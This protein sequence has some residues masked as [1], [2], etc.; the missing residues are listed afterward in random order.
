MS[1]HMIDDENYEEEYIYS[2]LDIFLDE[3]YMVHLCELNVENNQVLAPRE[4]YCPICGDLVSDNDLDICRC[5]NCE[6]EF[7]S[8]EG[9]CPFKNDYILFEVDTKEDCFYDEGVEEENYLSYYENCECCG[10]NYNCYANK[11]TYSIDESLFLTPQE[12]LNNDE[13]NE[14][15]SNS[16]INKND[17]TAQLITYKDSN[18]KISKTI[19]PAKE[20]YVK[21]E[22]RMVA[23]FME[24]PWNCSRESCKKI[25][26]SYG[27]EVVDEDSTKIDFQGLLFSIP[28]H[29][30][31]NFDKDGLATI[32]ILLIFNISFEKHFVHNK[33]KSTLTE[34]YG[35][36]SVEKDDFCFWCD[37]ERTGMASVGIKY[38][39]AFLALVYQSPKEVMKMFAPA[40]EAREKEIDNMKSLL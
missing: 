37:S 2:D 15:D 9:D 5:G 20:K 33:L 4:V 28:T 29:L 14:I 8:I 24:I 16:S 17:V 6:S 23:E 11:N 13:M 25:L 18:N 34:K 21:G 39:D 31:C 12:Y 10:F 30:S 40:L 36:L 3:L 27:Y 35:Q 19:A 22:K 1:Y 7:D 32:H 26:I 38:V